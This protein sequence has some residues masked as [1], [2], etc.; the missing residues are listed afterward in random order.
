MSHTIS[1][2]HNYNQK[3]HASML[4]AISNILRLEEEAIA[5]QCKDAFARLSKAEKQAQHGAKYSDEDY[6]ILDVLTDEDLI[7]IIYEFKKALLNVSETIEAMA[8]AKREMVTLAGKITAKAQEILDKQDKL[9]E[10]NKNPLRSEPGFWIT[11]IADANP[12][13][14]KSLIIHFLSDLTEIRTAQTICA[15]HAER[16]QLMSA[17]A[18][19]EAE[20]TTLKDDLSLAK[21]NMQQ[22]ED[23]VGNP[24]KLKAHKNILEA[25]VATLERDAKS[26]MATFGQQGPV[27]QAVVAQKQDNDEGLNPG[28]RGFSTNALI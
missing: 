25:N 4:E 7:A 12:G 24:E 27:A 23:E 15:R 11:F 9:N 20:N 18:A 10:L 22:R 2:L 5:S 21:T 13:F 3:T 17:V 16:N 8:R 26:L 19:L 28:I 1:I 6:C 14:V